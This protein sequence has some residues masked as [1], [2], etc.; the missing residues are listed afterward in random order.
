[1]LEGHDQLPL[2]LDTRAHPRTKRRPTPKAKPGQGRR[3]VPH[4]LRPEHADRHPVHVT[5]RAT[6]HL[7]SLRHERIRA[8][9]ERILDGTRTPQGQVVH[10]S[11]QRDHLHLVV[12]ASSKPELSSLLRRVVIRFALRLNKLLGR[13][14]GK[15]WDDRYHRRDLTSPRQVRHVLAY[16]FT[17]AA[18]HG[19]GAFAVR[20]GLDPHSSAAGFDRWFGLSPVLRRLLT[21]ERPRGPWRPPQP[22]TWLL[23]TGWWKTHGLL[24]FGLR[25]GRVEATFP[26]TV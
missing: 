20:V 24:I 14:K 13:A 9:V 22:R 1:M 2:P 16:V 10:F 6:R 18:K 21:R 17:N 26:L 12:E 11:I 25:P 15:V 8:L 5:L 7:P 23:H 4:R 3:R 19:E